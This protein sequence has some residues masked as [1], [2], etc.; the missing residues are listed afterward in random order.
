MGPNVSGFC[1]NS[2]D[3]FE[4]LYRGQGGPMTEV[5]EIVVLQP[6]RKTRKMHHFPGLELVPDRN[7]ELLGLLRGVVHHPAD[8]VAPVIFAIFL[9]FGDTKSEVK[10]KKN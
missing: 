6:L 7:G 8:V 5:Q 9:F 3:G 1:V 2:S 4:A 10:V